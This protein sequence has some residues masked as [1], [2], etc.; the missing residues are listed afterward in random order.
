MYIR[1]RRQGRVLRESLG[2]IVVGAIDVVVF[3]GQDAVEPVEDMLLDHHVVGVDA[4]YISSRSRQPA[5]S[6]LGEGSIVV[7][8]EESITSMD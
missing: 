2:Y 7:W 3:A 1:P 4:A 6:Y 5:S 8:R